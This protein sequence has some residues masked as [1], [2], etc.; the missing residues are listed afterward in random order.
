MSHKEKKPG[1]KKLFGKRF[2]AGSWSTLAAV[3][4]IVI[5]IVANLLVSSLPSTATEIDLTSNS[6]YELSDQTRRIVSSLEKDVKLYL[7]VVTG[8]EDSTITRLLNRYADLSDHITVET[9]DPN[10]KPTFLDSYDLN[11]SQ[12]YQNSVIVDCGGRYR[13]VGY[14]DIYVSSYSMDYSTYSYTTTT[15]FNGENELTNAIHYVSSDN[16][17]KVYVLTGHGESELSDDVTEMIEQD[18]MTYES[19]SLL[20]MEAVPEDANAVLINAPTSDLGD[21]ETEM[22]ITYLQNGGNVL[23][24]TDYIES[25]KMTNLLK[26]TAAMGVTVDSGI[27]IEGDSSRCINRY[28]HYILPNIQSHDITDALAD[29]GYYILMPIAQPIVET[30]D[31]TASVTWLLTTSD[32]AYAKQAGKSMTTTTKEDGDTDGPFNVGVAS[33]NG[34]KLVWFTSANMLNSNVDYTVGGANSN[35]VLNALNW[36]GDQEESISIRSKSMDEETLTVPSSSYSFW[37]VMMI[38]ILP[39]ALIAIGIFIYVR[40][41]HR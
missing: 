26:V 35:L 3:I 17:P 34:G 16:L 31:S 19:L 29:G 24:M 20:S 2:V 1:M 21:D 22:L 6:L 33:E 12:L 9:V 7:L 39:A 37:S 41:K 14:E 18:N 40:R 5:A 4:V 28:P 15:S 23:L 10:L 8:N 13:L 11:T 30:E 32:S 27:I 25:G 38:G 36:M